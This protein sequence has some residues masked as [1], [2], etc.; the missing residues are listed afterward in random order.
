MNDNKI[1]LAL[2]AGDPNG[3]GPEVMLKA[4]ATLNLKEVDVVVLG[5]KAILEAH[6]Q[7]FSLPMP[8][9][10]YNLPSVVP[11]IEWGK[12]SKSA[13]ELSMKAVEMAVDWCI[14]GRADAMVTAP[15]SKE[16]IG[17]AGYTIPGHTEFIAD[18]IGAKDLTMMLVCDELRIGLVTTHIPIAEVAKQ[19]QPKAI[20]DKVRIIH[21]SLI[22]DFGISSPRIAVLGLNPHAG[23]GGMIG[24]EEETIIRPALLEARRQGF[25]VSDPY[26][27]DGFFATRRWKDYDAVLAMYHDQ[28]LIPF[29]T[30][31]FERGVNFTAGLPLI[32]TSP[33][34]GTA[35]NIAGH[36]IASPESMKDAI[37]LAINLVKKRRVFASKNYNI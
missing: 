34:H 1:M 3:I 6:A 22:N 13:G 31:A 15:I 24:Q 2:S 26:A 30:I 33:D 23:D 18:R 5:H 11:F 9:K 28:G 21:H 25:N 7:H 29:K 16:A 17:L 35:F 12:I 37:I 36:G 19:V 20:L 10:V 8:A 4:L 32:R 14:S 27:A